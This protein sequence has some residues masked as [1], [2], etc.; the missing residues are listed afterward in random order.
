MLREYREQ[1][2]RNAP[3]PEAPGGLNQPGEDEPDR[4]D[5]MLEMER[6]LAESLH[7]SLYEMD[8]TDIESLI[9]FIL[10]LAKKGKKTSAK[11]VYADQVD[12]L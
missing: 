8:R 7:W 3:K 12:W 11:K 10:H 5:W 9:P 1:G 6:I 2:E 4:E